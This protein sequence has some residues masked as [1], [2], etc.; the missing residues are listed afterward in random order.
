M[1]SMI[2]IA[3]GAN[4]GSH[5]GTPEKTML[6]ALSAMT[7]H[8]MEIV[9]VSSF[10]RTCAWPD[11]DDPPFVNAVARIETDLGTQ[12]LL[13]TLHQIESDFGRIRRKRYGPRTLDLDLIDYRGNVADESPILPHP[14]MH[15]RVFVLVPLAEIAP[16]WRHPKTGKSVA[17]LIAALPPGDAA[18]VV[19]I[20]APPAPGAL[21][22]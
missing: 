22:P 10:Y 14:R 15:E 3:L 21:A 5:V 1:D 13:E 4:I 20:S 17:E 9:S 19:R 8:G 2:V 6:A 11:P 7:A 12:K 16:D 18:G